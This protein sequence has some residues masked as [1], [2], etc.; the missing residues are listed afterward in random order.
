MPDPS[1]LQDPVKDQDKAHPI[2]TAWRPAFREIVGA[3]VR[4]DYSLRRP[5]QSVEPV[6]VGTADQVKNYVASH[7][8]TLCELPD[9]TWRTSVS[10]W[11]EGYWDVLVDLWTV[12]SGR[13]DL[14][15]FARVRE[16]GDGF[17]IEIE[18]VHVP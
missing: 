8:E 10:Q 17:R 18:S 6:P 4:R 16:V 9:E 12:E 11:M 5:V 1:E 13:S 15:L 14:V 7:G 3:F 2:A